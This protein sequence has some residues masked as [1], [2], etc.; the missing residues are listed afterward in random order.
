LGIALFFQ[1]GSQEML[2]VG[3]VGLELEGVAKF[4]V[5]LI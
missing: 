4:C 5:G 3:G 2:G 1:D